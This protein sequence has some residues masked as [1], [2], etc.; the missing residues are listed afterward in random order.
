MKRKAFA[1]LALAALLVGAFAV[2]A[3]G[4][5]DQASP[6]TSA[7]VNMSGA[8]PNFRFSSI[9]QTF[10]AGTVRFSLRNTSSGQVRHNFVVYRVTGQSPASVRMVR[11]FASRDLAAGQ[12]QTLSRNVRAGFYVAICT[13]GNGFHAANRMTTSFQAQ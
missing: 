8:P 3:L 4:R 6:A 5:G 11:S 13:I 1:V 10:K 2:T 7:T 9:P 12:R